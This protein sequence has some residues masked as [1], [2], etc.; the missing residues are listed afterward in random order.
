MFFHY[1]KWNISIV[2]YYR[3]ALTYYIAHNALLL[4][5]DVSRRWPTLQTDRPKP[6]LKHFIDC[7]KALQYHRLIVITMYIVLIVLYVHC[8]Y[9][10][11]VSQCGSPALLCYM[12]IMHVAENLVFKCL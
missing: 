5:S 12:K 4:H 3:E 2:S 7:L 11:P 8:H 9:T 10:L 6:A 1:K